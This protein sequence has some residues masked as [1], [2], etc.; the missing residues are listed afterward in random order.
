VITTPSRRPT[1][2][3][4]PA[5]PEAERTPHVPAPRADRV[6]T[7]AQ[8]NRAVLQLRERRGKAA[9]EQLQAVLR[10]LDL[11]VAPDQ[12]APGPR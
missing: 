10:A 12:D 7:P 2:P 4:C 6:V 11:T 9:A 1:E 3:D 8:V 5:A